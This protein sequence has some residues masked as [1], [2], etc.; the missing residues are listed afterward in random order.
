PT[1]NACALDSWRAQLPRATKMRKPTSCINEREHPARFRVWMKNG[2]PQSVSSTF[3][4]F[5]PMIDWERR[6]RKFENGDEPICVCEDAAR[7]M[8]IVR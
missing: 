5:V 1:G 2:D 4:C 8:G 6:W 7:E 3:T